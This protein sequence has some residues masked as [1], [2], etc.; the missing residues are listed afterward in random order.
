MFDV[1]YFIQFIIVHNPVRFQ[2]QDN[3]AEQS[4][5]IHAQQ[6]PIINHQLFDSAAATQTLQLQAIFAATTEALKTAIHALVNGF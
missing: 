4:I 5:H 1:L 3:F 2:I 6:L